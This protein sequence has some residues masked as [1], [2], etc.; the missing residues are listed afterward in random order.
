MSQEQGI[1]R[2]LTLGEVVSKTFDVYKRG[3]TKFVVLFLVVEV[4]IGVLT[5]LVQR[6]F[7]V[8]PLIPNPTPQ[9]V[10]SWLPGFFGALV[11]L[12][13]LTT[14]AAFLFYP[15]A[16]GSTVKMT[17]DEV[18]KGQSNLGGSIRF[19]FSKLLW[20]W[21]LSIIVGIIVLLGLIALIIPGIILAIMFSLTIPVLLIENPG[22]LESMGR[23]RKLVSQRWLK[24]FALVL[25]FG[26]IVAIAGIVVSVIALPFGAASGVVSGILS[27]FYQPL[28]PIAIT[29]YYFS[30]VARTT[31]PQAGMAPSAPMAPAA[32]VQ[33][34]MKFCPKCSA[35]MPSTA[36][37]CPKCG[38]PQ[39]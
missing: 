12:V 5:A 23:S 35:Q 27:A 8:P 19:A 7:V 1:S 30:N 16:L 10:Y 15:I 37:L 17:S 11:P 6:T 26:I 3:F 38:A 20:I 29:V 39:P 13:A 18:T 4:V 34:G 22:V 2:E 14:L 33:G 31:A 36:T 24:T 25:I 28:L 21:V 9:Q 32:D